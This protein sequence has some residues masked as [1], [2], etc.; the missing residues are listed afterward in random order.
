MHL[1]KCNSQWQNILQRGKELEKKPEKKARSKTDEEL[2]LSPEDYIKNLRQKVAKEHASHAGSSTKQHG[3]LRSLSEPVEELKKSERH[4]GSGIEDELPPCV[5][6]ECLSS[7]ALAV[8]R[9]SPS[10]VESCFSHYQQ[11]QSSP[12]EGTSG[13]A[14]PSS[15]PLSKTSFHLEPD[16]S[17]SLTQSDGAKDMK[18]KSKE[19]ERRK[20]IIQAVSDFFHKKKESSRSPSPPKISLENSHSTKDKFSRFRLNRHKDKG[21]ER[22]PLVPG[23]MQSKSGSE[24]SSK[25]LELISTSDRSPPPVPPPPLNYDGGHIPMVSED[26]CSE[27]EEN[28]RGT[29]L[30]TSTHDTSVDGVTDN[31]NRRLS[32]VNRRVARQTELKRLRMAQEIQRQLEE[33]EVKQ[34]ELEQRGVTLEKALRGE[35]ADAECKEESELLREWF[36]L[37]RERTELR[38]YERELMVRAQEMELEDR[39]ARLRQELQD[40]MSRDDSS[41]SSEDVVKEGE[42][43][44]EILEIVEQRDSLIALLEE[45]RQRYQ[46]EDKDL[47]AQML[48]KGLRLT[49][50]RKESH[51]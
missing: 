15:A 25:H 42:I 33:L 36:D 38:H 4:S 20:S 12:S 41:K 8:S 28:S 22:V 32:R 23:D 13:A 47:E 34:R 30:S 37:M 3:I 11:L 24:S 27:P 16:V 43:L 6:A 51:V 5:S 29:V 18:K 48:A 10:P 1:H 49:P 31:Q 40:R 14:S 2:G 21:K 44:R 17:V 39:H 9:L 46:E 19:R 45:D 50:L 35:G 7:A 26:S